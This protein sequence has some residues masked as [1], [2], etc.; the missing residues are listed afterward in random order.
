MSGG[1]QDYQGVKGGAMPNQ[2]LLG[3]ISARILRSGVKSRLRRGRAREKENFLL[4]K[5]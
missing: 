1:P 5:Y 2:F 3:N 4:S